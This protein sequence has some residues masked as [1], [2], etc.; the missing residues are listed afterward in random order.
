MT[1]L[2]VYGS[3]LDPAVQS[4]VINRNPDLQP[5]TLHGYAKST[6]NLEGESWYIAEQ[7]DMGSND[8]MIMELRDDELA[9]IDEWEGDSYQRIQVG[10]N[11]Y[12]FARPL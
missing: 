12:L 9:K 2:F 11:L 10:K 8:G 4:E 3:L 5:Y 7:S 6:I 1:K